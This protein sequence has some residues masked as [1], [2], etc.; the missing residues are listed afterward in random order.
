MCIYAPLLNV[1]ESFYSEL[2][3]YENSDHGLL[4]PLFTSS[5]PFQPSWT[6]LHRVYLAL[7]H[8]WRRVLPQHRQDVVGP[9]CLQRQPHEQEE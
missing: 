6:S 9:I 1:V 3:R 8:S 7:E 4:T 2:L 5:L